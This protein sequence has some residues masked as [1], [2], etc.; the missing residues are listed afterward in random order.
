M[1]FA[2]LELFDH[3]LF[4]VMKAPADLAGAALTAPVAIAGWAIFAAP[5]ILVLLWLFG[6]TDDRRAAIRATFVATAGLTISAII[7]SLYFHPR[8]FMDGASRN[9]LSHAV[10]SSFPSDHAAVLFALAFSLVLS[11][12]RKSRLGGAILLIVAPAVGWA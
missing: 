11:R 5:A 9:F 1:T 10:D 12:S 3:S 4:R 8:P 7:S 6:A 2:T